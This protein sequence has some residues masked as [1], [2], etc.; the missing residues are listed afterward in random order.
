M[1]STLFAAM[2]AALAGTAV[3]GG[4]TLILDDFDN[5][6]NDDAGGPRDVSSVI[7]ADPFGQP[8][9]FNVDTGF[10]FGGDTGAAVFNSGI[11]V[12]Q[13]GRI[14]YDNNGSGLN[15]DAAA[16]GLAGFEFDFLAV[17]QDFE[18]QIQLGTDGGGTADFSGTIN[19][20]TNFSASFALASFTIGAGFDAADVDSVLLTFNDADGATP[21][22]DFVLT[23][24]R[25][26][27]PTPGALAML[28]VGG[29]V[30]AG[31]RR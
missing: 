9:T 7:N 24:F 15:L 11:G 6:P 19:A 29:L 21:S 2:I 18:I 23:E 30:A 26:T 16:L 3:A 13:E 12:E 20:G 14:L 4:P 17:D 25:A 28:A 27:V 5:D 22:L 10:S 31:R 1:K 8:A